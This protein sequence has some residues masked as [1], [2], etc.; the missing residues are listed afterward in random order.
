AS[1]AQLAADGSAPRRV[2]LAA[3][4]SA[5][6]VRPAP[7][8]DAAGVAGVVLTAAVPLA[9]LASVH[10]D[11]VEAEPAVRAAGADPESEPLLQALEEHDLLWWATQELDALLAALP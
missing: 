7:D 11:D 1:L 6:A 2:V 10:V 5:G 9:D 8:P 3:E 4:V